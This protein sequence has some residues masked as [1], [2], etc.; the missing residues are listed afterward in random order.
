LGLAQESKTEAEKKKR[1]DLKE[2]VN[3]FDEAILPIFDP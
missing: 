2:Y 1:E 3:V